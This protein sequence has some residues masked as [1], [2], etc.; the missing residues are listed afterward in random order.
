MVSLSLGLS[1]VRVNELV[2]GVVW[3]GGWGM[4][5]WDIYIKEIYW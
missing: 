3:C 1:I 4:G 5:G 2:C